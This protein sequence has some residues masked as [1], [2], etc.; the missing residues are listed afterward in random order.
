MNNRVNFLDNLRAISLLS[1][2]LYHL[3]YD[4]HYIFNINIPWDATINYIW[5]QATSWTFI[6]I[7][8]ASVKYSKNGYKRATQIFCIG[9]SIT[10]ITYFF[11]RSQVIYFGIL[12][13]IGISMFILTFFK[14]FFNKINKYLLFVISF[15]LFTLSKGIYN[16]FLGFLDTPLFYLPRQFFQSTYLFMFGLPNKNFISS[17]YFPIIPWIFLYFTGYFLWQIIDTSIINNKILNFENKFIAFIGKN[18]LI[19]Y[20]LH[21]P[22]IYGLLLLILN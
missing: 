20:I 19:L 6:L 7:S 4:L 12:H 11:M 21:Q 1:M 9:M 18:S 16:G 14:K 3:V 8:G 2:I 13:F 17:D 5:Q 10:F 22:I 15:S